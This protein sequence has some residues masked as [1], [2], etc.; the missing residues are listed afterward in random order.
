MKQVG[1]TSGHCSSDPVRAFRYLTFFEKRRWIDCG[2]I[3][4]LV[5]HPHLRPLTSPLAALLSASSTIHQKIAPIETLT[6]ASILRSLSN[7][8]GL[9]SLDSVANALTIPPIHVEHVADAIC[10]AIEDQMV[11]GLVGVKDMRR[12]IGWEMLGKGDIGRATS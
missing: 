7:T 5:Y 8:T 9:S 11:R 3:S 4:G 6:P 12:L 10:I 1:I 2:T